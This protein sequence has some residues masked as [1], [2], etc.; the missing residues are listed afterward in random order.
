M[1][2][3]PDILSVPSAVWYFLHL[4]FSICRLGTTVYNCLSAVERGAGW[5]VIVLICV[6]LRLFSKYLLGMFS[7]LGASEQGEVAVNLR[8]A[9]PCET[10]FLRRGHR[11]KEMS[12]HLEGLAH[13]D[14]IVL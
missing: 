9:L 10:E 3:S 6:S 11:F 5:A 13:G 12:R 4:S 2:G 7:L 8:T 1:L 14:A